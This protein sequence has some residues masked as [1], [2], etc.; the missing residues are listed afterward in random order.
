MDNKTSATHLIRG[1]HAEQLACDYLQASG[2]Q[3]LR[4]NYRLR[5]GEID[6][7]MCEQDLII[8]VEVRYR[9]NAQYGGALYSISSAKQRRII[10]TAA[11]YL[12]HYAP[13]AQ[14]RFDVIAVEG[15]NDINWIQNA[16]DAS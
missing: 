13:T 7:I 10:R 6:L 16:F 2:L 5:S 12:Q 3:L 4:R 9:R 15:D 11:H 1:S 14:A 8:F